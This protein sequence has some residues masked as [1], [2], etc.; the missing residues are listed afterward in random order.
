MVQFRADAPNMQLETQY[1]PNYG[2]VHKGNDEVGTKRK[3]K[4]SAE[5]NIEIV[6]D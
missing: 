6:G 3:Y 4:T 1:K 5:Q 2:I